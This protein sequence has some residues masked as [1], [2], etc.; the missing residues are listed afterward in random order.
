M[1]G[2]PKFTALCVQIDSEV[3]GELEIM[4]RVGAGETSKSIAESYGVSYE[5]LRRWLNL[6]PERRRAYDAAK[7]DSADALVEEAGEILDDADAESGPSVQKA[8]SR[9]E[10]RRWLASKRDRQQY[11]DD[12][13]ANVQVNVDLSSLHLDALRE[14][15]HMD[16]APLAEVELLP[17]ES[18]PDGPRQG[19]RT[20]PPNGERATETDDEGEA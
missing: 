19:V 15:G 6:H 11:G 18:G 14:V 17:D 2:Q 8:K 4:E 7:A 20:A 1:P 5:L 3:D 10:H 12:A 16:H 9:A 13:K